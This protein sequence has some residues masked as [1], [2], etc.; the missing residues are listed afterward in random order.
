VSV[1]AGNHTNTLYSLRFL[2][3]HLHWNFFILLGDVIPLKYQQFRLIDVLQMYTASYIYG[4]WESLLRNVTFKLSNIKNESIF[5]HVFSPCYI[6]PRTSMKM[7]Y[8]NWQL[9]KMFWIMRTLKMTPKSH[10]ISTLLQ[11]IWC[12]VLS[13]L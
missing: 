4:T 12:Y 2:L 8:F 6:F 3:H 7:E 9:M 5:T 1:H 11:N 10:L 13:Y